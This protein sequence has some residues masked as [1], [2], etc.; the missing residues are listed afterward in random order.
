MTKL[1]LVFAASLFLA[2]ISE[3]NTRAILASGHRY[4]VWNDWAYIALVV[5]LT[6]FTGLRTNYNDTWNY[7]NAFRS[8][9]DLP[10]YLASPDAW[11][12][13]K[14]PL[15]YF[16]QSCLKTVTDN[17]QWLI[18][19]TSA[20]TQI[21][22]LR[23]FKRYSEHFLFSVFI[24]FALDTFV[25][26]LAA[27]KQVAAM[28]ILT[29]SFPYLEKGKWG[30]YYLIVA[31]A[32][33]IHTYAMAFF[34][35][36]FFR[37]RPWRLFTFLFVAAMVFLMFNFEETITAFMEQANDLGKTLADYEVFD[38]YTIN[39]FRLAVYAVPPVVS[40]AFQAWILRNSTRMDNIFIHMSIISLAFM[41]MGT[42]S[43]A[44]MFARMATYFE[45]GTICIL[46]KMLEK[47][48]ESRSYRLV[49]GLAIICFFGFFAYANAISGSFDQE[50]RWIIN[51]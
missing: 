4:S 3:Q 18:F 40:F 43:G 2:Y 1:L 23:F 12:L 33:M 27:L 17:A 39:V 34:I 8:A 24:Y 44:N 14:N 10:T 6:L 50:F 21:C 13:F 51:W 28:A 15:F 20:I 47:T 36:P 9:P 48:F 46:P 32:M 22:L 29:L 42:Q 25:F 31:V 37:T 41:S 7:I 26:T 11:N 38:D 49:S 35:L 19:T 45:L 5:V 16:F 30:R